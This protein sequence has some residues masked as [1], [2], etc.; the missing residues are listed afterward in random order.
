M[1]KQSGDKSYIGDGVYVAL[2]RGMICLTTEEGR[3]IP[4]IIYLEPEVWRALKLWVEDVEKHYPEQVK[5][6]NQ[7]NV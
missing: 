7:P 4:N 3:P 5:N 1:S 6:A 2:D